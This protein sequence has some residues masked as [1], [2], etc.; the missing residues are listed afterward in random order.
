MA[1]L[2]APSIFWRK[3]FADRL[4]RQSAARRWLSLALLVTV[5]AATGCHAQ[6]PW[7]LWEKYTQHFMDSS[8]R[9]VDHDA[10]DRTTSEGQSYAMF[11]A[12]VDNDRPAFD[13]LLHWTEANLADG[14][15]SARLPG[16]NWGKS[17]DGEWKLLDTHTAADSDVWIAYS[18]LEAG[19]LWHEP[20]Y[21][22][23][24][25][26]MLSRIAAE[27]VALVPGLGTTL[28]G[29][30]QGFHP[31][32][33]VWILN[34]CYLPPSLLERFAA[35]QPGG[36]WR[37]VLSSLR[38]MLDKGSGAGF[39]MDWVEAGAGVQPSETPVQ[40]A[41]GTKG[42]PAIGSYD[43][44][45][46]Y[47]WLGIADPSTPALGEFLGDMY[48]MTAL[49]KN[50][51]MPPAKVDSAGKVIEP[52]GPVGFSAALAPFLLANGL[53]P[54]AKAQMDRVAAGRDATT[55]LYGQGAHY[56]DQNL[57]LFGTGWI[58]ER[59]RFDREGR[60]KVAWKK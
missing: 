53:K 35:A 57:V 52:N 26:S 20:R 18:L 39:A 36:P 51:P 2:F 24:G 60:L 59:F 7:P 40:L 11:F 42:V 34:P 28:I 55:G 8:G 6:Q 50:Q 14:D 46:V 3:D 43:A 27:E 31:E 49:I 44:I 10:Q 12:L 32:P 23:L 5:S 47:L 38:P 56:Y 45:R 48:G 9:I 13:K 15:L 25:L 41:A 17:P 54:E 19:R 16:W 21:E 30:N 4:A 1:F 37:S 29:G 22:K 33:T 58:E